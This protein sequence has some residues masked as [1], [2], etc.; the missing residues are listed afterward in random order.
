MPQRRDQSLFRRSRL[1]RPHAWNGLRHLIYPPHGAPA[2]ACTGVSPVGSYIEDLA[3]CGLLRS[4]SSKG[5]HSL[6]NYVDWVVISY[7]NV[8]NLDHTHLTSR[9]EDL[10]VVAYSKRF[11][12]S[13]L[14]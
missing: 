4:C 3:E 6:P 2:R 5:L 1:V 10:S 7:S 9:R 14:A 8:K 13:R 12:P 11:E